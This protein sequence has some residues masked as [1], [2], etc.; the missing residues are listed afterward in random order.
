VPDGLLLCKRQ[1]VPI[2][3]TVSGLLAEIR[4]QQQ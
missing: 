4:P 1:I 2:W 3:A